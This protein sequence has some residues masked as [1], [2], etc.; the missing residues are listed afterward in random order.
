MIYHPIV[1]L[2]RSVST[3]KCARLFPIFLSCICL[4]R[5]MIVF[6]SWVSDCSQYEAQISHRL[7]AIVTAAATGAP[8][9]VLGICPS[10]WTDGHI[11]LLNTSVEL[12]VSTDPLISFEG[13]KYLLFLSCSLIYCVLILTSCTSVSCFHDTDNIY[14]DAVVYVW[15]SPFRCLQYFIYFPTKTIHFCEGL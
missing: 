5:A 7:C 1:Y 13:L 9:V 2:L 10:R 14:R 15:L 6:V 12:E 11:K 3:L 8:A 4:S